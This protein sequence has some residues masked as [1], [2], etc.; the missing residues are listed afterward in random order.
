MSLQIPSLAAE[1]YIPSPRDII[2]PLKA[3]RMSHWRCRYENG[4]LAEVSRRD[5]LGSYRPMKPPP[6]RAPTNGYLF[7]YSPG[8]AYL[9]DSITAPDGIIYHLFYSPSNYLAE[10]VCSNTFRGKKVPYSKIVILRDHDG[11]VTRISYW[12]GTTPAQN[13]DGIHATSLQYDTNGFLNE[14]Q[15][16]DSRSNTCNNCNG[17]ARKVYHRGTEGEWLSISYWNESGAPATDWHGVSRYEVTYNDALRFKTTTLFGPDDVPAENALGGHTLIWQYDSLYNLIGTVAV[18]A[19]GNTVFD[20]I[21]LMPELFYRTWPEAL[22]TREQRELAVP[23]WEFMDY[24]ELVNALQRWYN[25]KI[26][27]RGVNQLQLEQLRILADYLVTSRSGITAITAALLCRAYGLTDPRRLENAI[28]YAG[29]MPLPGT[30]A[31]NILLDELTA[32]IQT[33]AFLITMHDQSRFLLEH[34]FFTD[35]IDDRIVI[36]PFDNIGD[37]I[38]IDALQTLYADYETVWLPSALTLRNALQAYAG[39]LNRGESQ[40]DISQLFFIDK[41]RIALRGAENVAEIK[42]LILEDVL[43]N[44]SNRIVYLEAIPG[45]TSLFKRMIPAGPFFQLY[46]EHSQQE[47]RAH[48]P[49]VQDYWNA[50]RTRLNPLSGGTETTACRRYFALAATAQAEWLYYHQYTN[51]AVALFRT[52]IDICP[53]APEP[54]LQLGEKLINQEQFSEAAG[55]LEEL[56]AVN[57]DDAGA[58]ELILFLSEAR[59]RVE[60]IKHLETVIAASKTLCTSNV[61]NLAELYAVQNRPVKAA[62]LAAEL[63]ANCSNCVETLEWLVKFYASNN[64]LDDAA[65]CLARL[66]RIEPDSFD[67]WSSRAAIAYERNRPDEGLQYITRAAEIDTFRLRRMLTAG[68]FLQEL[69]K[70]GN[71]NLVE[72]LEQL[73]R[74]E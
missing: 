22:I 45:D 49:A 70:D 13:Y 34:S 1:A 53:S 31:A 18:D 59:S 16:V 47:S 56:R 7:H 23:I 27:R 60:R 21:P 20:G 40:S 9:P 5:Y 38:Y 62:E 73:I 44:N 63:S 2:D 48:A 69:L 39:M 66:T 29:C 35:T 52:A 30:P 36:L 41:D 14:V 65:E 58:D 32:V 28:R 12:N 43:R 10:I 72:Q 6:D 4:R 42:K 71:T 57:T 46:A 24:S 19:E 8:S 64:R 68:N 17:I 51:E 26:A 33:S 11:L 54:Y 55:V 3:A 74:I 15:Y 50:V 67:H 25:H 37:S 61:M